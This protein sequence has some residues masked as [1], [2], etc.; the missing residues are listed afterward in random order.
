MLER[1]RAAVTLAVV[2]AHVTLIVV[3]WRSTGHVAE[4]VQITFFTLPITLADRPRELAHEE[5]QPISRT[6][7][8]VPRDASAAR[9][10]ATASPHVEARFGES[11]RTEPL[12]NKVEA[13]AGMP[14]ALVD[15]RAEVTASAEALAQRDSI[16]SQRRSLAGPKQGPSSVSRP[17]PACPYEECEPDWKP[18]VGMFESQHSRRGRIQKI[19]DTMQNPP[20]SPQN[21][22]EGEVIRWINSWCYFTLVT[23]NPLHRRL[24]RCAV[25]IGKEVPRG[26]LFKNMGENPSL[27][28]RATDVP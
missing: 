7:E 5:K 18:D 9:A 28:S 15:W 2:A 14:A 22:P 13:R 19:P 21:T 6:A 1:R 10:P 16:E 8:H 20:G 25:P 23:A 17:T 27:E 12:D 11:S 4:V 24:I 26:D 3:M